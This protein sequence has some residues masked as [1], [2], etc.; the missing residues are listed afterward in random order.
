MPEFLVPNLSG[1]T[2]YP[3]S[4][5]DMLRIDIEIPFLNPTD[6]RYGQDNV[7]VKYVGIDGTIA[8]P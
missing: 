7:V 8:T 3:L 5:G 2:E 6:I 1:G 4:A